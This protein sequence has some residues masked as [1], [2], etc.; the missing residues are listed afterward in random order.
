M[1]KDS[2]FQDI[3]LEL[4]VSNETLDKIEKNSASL[5]KVLPDVVASKNNLETSAA[6]EIKGEDKDD[7]GVNECCNSILKCLEQ[8]KITAEFLAHEAVFSGGILVQ[9]R[10]SLF[11]IQN[12][13]TEGRRAAELSK[14]QGSEDTR[15]SK[16]AAAKPAKVTAAAKSGG[17]DTTVGT[18]PKLAAAGAAAIAGFLPAA[19]AGF[20]R[21]FRK[22]IGRSFSG[23]VLEQAT[24]GFKAAKAKIVETGG[25]IGKT[26]NGI[27]EAF[28]ERFERLQSRTKAFLRKT[29][30][31]TKAAELA[32][33]VEE[34]FVATKAKVMEGLKPLS[35]GL[36]E[37]KAGLTEGA[38]KIVASTRG[39]IADVAESKAITTLSTA[40]RNIRASLAELGNEAKAVAKTLSEGPAE[41][42][43]G[44]GEGLSK[45]GAKVREAAA[46]VKTLYRGVAEEISGGAK[47]VK[48]A[49]G[50]GMGKISTSTRELS[51]AFRESKFGRFL[52][53]I[54]ESFSSIGAAL[55]ELSGFF[56]G[57]KGIATRIYNAVIKPFADFF[58]TF[59]QLF[60]VFGKL[61]TAV[62]ELLGKLALPVTIIFGILDFFKGFSEEKGDLTA[63]FKAGMIELVN[64][65]VGWLVDIPKSIIS[66]IAGALGFKEIEKTLDA[67]NFK[68][69][70]LKPVMAFG[71]KLF[72][73]LFEW[74]GSMTK[75]IVKAI[76]PKS[77]QKFLGVDQA[78]ELTGAE[79]RKAAGK[80]RDEAMLSNAAKM[81][82]DP[83]VRLE[84]KQDL[85]K[86]LE[87]NYGFTAKEI[88]DAATKA[89]AADIKNVLESISTESP[90]RVIRPENRIVNPQSD[91]ASANNTGAVMTAYQ[92]QTNDLNTAAATAP[93]IVAPSESAAPVV[94]NT[95]SNSV[96]YNNTA[97]PDRT[98]Q[99]L[100]PA[101]GY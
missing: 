44:L 38:Q 7:S 37:I 70:I 75:T 55:E 1:E 79:A 14:L 85:I 26:F 19:V 4:M 11:S 30:I 18:I 57:P 71:E 81:L 16:G 29:G 62:G 98:Y 91:V 74:L 53:S 69:S 95:N 23:K 20:A 25:K 43:A 82:A 92:T 35:D 77:V 54:G 2:T 42:R 51:I 27:R 72:T 63:K 49:F 28:T 33:K 80:Y 45:I 76:L 9:I 101:F 88:T 87:S 24:A 93:V 50:E 61:G 94:N 8:V 6:A 56:T 21:Q 40:T 32:T 78:P 100:T 96:T 31:D 41:V 66:W 48:A 13:I 15:E 36:K 34:V 10:N 68:D 46:E 97:L 52:T 84:R 39:I 59:D 83:T 17:G 12:D 22:A 86:N 73:Y 47:E 90:E 64:G 5:L 58:K 89:G 99:Y 65:L 3:L 60:P 67:F